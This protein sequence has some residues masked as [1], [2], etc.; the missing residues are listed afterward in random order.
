[1]VG[2]YWTIANNGTAFDSYCVT[3]NFTAADLGGADPDKLVVGKYDAGV[4]TYP[5]VTERTSTSVKVCGLTSFSDFVLGEMMS[6]TITASAGSNGT[7]DPVGAVSVAHGASQSFTIT[8]DPDYAVQDVLV[9]DVSVGAVTSY[10]FTN[11]TTDH[12]IAASFMPA[13]YNRVAAV[14]TTVCITPVR[15]CLTIPVNIARSE[16]TDLR[17]FHV[18]FTLSPEL[19]LCGAGTSGV[20]EGTYLSNRNPNTTFLVVDNGG[21]SYTADGTINGLPCGQTALTGNLFNLEVGSN[22]G[23]GTGTITVTAVALRD[24]DNGDILPASAGAP[25]TVTFDATPVTIADIADQT[26]AELAGLT[27][28]PSVTITACATG[29]ATWGISPSLPGGATFSTGSGEIA[30]TPDCSQAGSY[31]PYTLTA[32]A[33]SGESDTE[34]FSILV[35]DTPG[36]VTVTGVTSPYAVEE[37]SALAMA[38]PGVTL[39]GCAAGRTP[40]WSLGGASLPAALRSARRRARSP[41]RRTAARPG[42]YGPYT[43]TATVTAVGGQ[44]YSGSETFSITATHK[45]GLVTVT[46]VSDPTVAELATATLTLGATLG[47]CATG[48][49]T[50][51]V[52]PALPGWA[53]LAGDV[54]TITPG[55]AEAEGG[56]G[57]TYGPYTVTATAGTGETGTATFSIHVTDTPGGVVVT[58]VTSPYAV[59]EKSALAMAVPG[60]DL[61]GCAAGMTPVWSLWARCRAG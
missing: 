50:Y 21:G 2:S 59:E 39:T 6:H 18:D 10:P 49:V 5:P 34:L 54:I 44:T 51:G 15:P 27:I 22:G 4:W 60:L 33:A 55:C 17:G 28:T 41:G 11:V 7:I 29:P 52:S 45:A 48:P 43:L 47:E 3:F 58:G 46:G 8:P 40:V 12:T 26:V 30:W 14:G 53:S 37:K 16:G 1:M 13:D 19:K 20:A 31:G 42:R 61:T 56:A 9:D 32:T 38:A 25:A 57:G 24:C 23:S 36:G 35:T